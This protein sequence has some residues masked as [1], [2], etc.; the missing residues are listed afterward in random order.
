[1]KQRRISPVLHAD[2]NCVFRKGHVCICVCETEGGEREGERER[3]RERWGDRGGVVG[4]NR[5]ERENGIGRLGK[6]GV[7]FYPMRP[8]S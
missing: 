4:R 2:L 5:R 8:E 1:M 7:T 6:G 3:E